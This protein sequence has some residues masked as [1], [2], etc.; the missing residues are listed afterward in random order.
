MKLLTI[1]AILLVFFTATAYSGEV[2]VEPYHGW[3]SK[4]FHTKH[5][6]SD[7]VI[8]LIEGF[9]G[10]EHVFHQDRYTVTVYIG[11]AFSWSEIEYE[12]VSALS[13]RESLGP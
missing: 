13:K 3:Y 11:K 12:I 8:N 1:L 5:D 4:S 6:I 9:R 2:V 10:V 7:S